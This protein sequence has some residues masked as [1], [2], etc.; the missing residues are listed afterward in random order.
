MKKALLVVMGMF[1]AVSLAQAQSWPARPVKLLVPFPPGGS[2]D[3]TARVVADKL[4][5]ALGQQ[6]VVENRAGASGAIGTSEVARGAADGYTILFAADPVETLPLVMKDLQFDLQRDFLPVTQVTTQPLALAVHPSLG[7]ASVQELV[8]LAK[9]QPGKLSFAHSGIGTGQHF[10]GEL[11][12][13]LAGID[14]QHVP[15]KGG[16]PAVK[17]FIAGQVKVAMLGS[18]P[19]IPHHKAGRI[20]IIAFSSKHRF[21]TLPDVP[22]LH[23]LGY[24]IDTGQWL[25]LLAPRGTRAEVVERLYRE[26]KK[27]LELDDVK[28]RLLQAALLP[29]GSTPSQFA[30]LIRADVEKWTKLAGELGIKPQ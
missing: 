17:D 23:E 4:S 29:V 14:I 11:F 16:G 26:T 13:K 9:K 6:F 18:T 3:L 27:V 7:V 2:T 8:A 24:P 20:K 10:T 15:Y 25:G 28:E 19:V 1:C 22:T 21:P 30:A 12:R 5:R